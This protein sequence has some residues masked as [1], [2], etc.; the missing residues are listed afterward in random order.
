V[1]AFAYLSL[2]LVLIERKKKGRGSLVFGIEQKV[3]E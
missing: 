3:G 1:I 2:Q